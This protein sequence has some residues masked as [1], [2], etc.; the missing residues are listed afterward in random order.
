MDK[1]TA[2][3]IFIFLIKRYSMK[4]VLLKDLV[5]K[6]GLAVYQSSDYEKI[7]IELNEVNRPVYN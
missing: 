4:S 7:E 5:L 3:N 1:K 2:K 6:L